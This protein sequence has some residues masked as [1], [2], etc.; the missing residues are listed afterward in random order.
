M[1]SGSRA[2]QAVITIAVAAVAGV[3]AVAA[4]LAIGTTTSTALERAQATVAL[5][6]LS[7][8]ASTSA[9]G[10]PAASLIDGL[11]STRWRPS[12]LAVPQRVTLDLGSA[13]AVG[14]SVVDWDARGTVGFHL[15]GSA[16]GS[17]WTLLGGQRA[18][19]SRRTRT[20]TAGTWRYLRIRIERS[21]VGAAGIREWRVYGF[22]VA[23]DPVVP[24]P[25]PTA[26]P[27]VTPAPTPTVTPT[28]TASPT[29][30]PT[31]SPTPT[32]TPPPAAA[33]P[34]VP[35]GWKLVR[36]TTIRDLRTVGLRNTYF[37]NVTFTGGSATTAVVQ[38]SSPASG[39]TFDHCTIAAGGGWN[40]VSINDSS[41]DI[42]D[43]TF[44]HVLFKGQGRMGIEITSRPT[45]AA[46]GYRNISII[47]S[48]FEPQGSEAVSYDGGPGAGWST[49]RD[50]LIQ[51]AGVNPV[52]QY[53][54]GF[55]VNGDSN[56]TVTGNVIWQCRESAWN[57]QRH[58]T[59][60]SGWVFSGNLLDASR[61]QQVVPMKALAQVV[62][63]CNVYGG[64]FD[65]NT[66]IA[67]APGGSVAYIDDSHDMDWRTT[68]WSDA[69][70]GGFAKP[71]EAAGSSGNLW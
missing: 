49:F 47:D 65:H 61:H 44:D 20:T 66:V 37:W 41:G 64:V 36:D 26:T 12:G 2:S 17:R 63:A 40:G 28:R 15:F 9:P 70:G 56:M 10:H 14:A 46:V 60:P 48:T 11:I 31:P 38:F 4:W 34:A 32:P 43:I 18:S 59:T 13:Q 33:P 67:E 42:H 52:Q 51:G 5:P 54:S 69:R 53:G 8:S 68:T 57:L 45:T 3:C 24:T 1:R 19:R 29:P 50:N 58:V 27:T 55:E 25:T 21:S 23:P 30:T 62:G 71:T 6:A 39:I 22:A 35:A 16:D 7:A